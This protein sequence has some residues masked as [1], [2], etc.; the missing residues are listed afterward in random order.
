[1]D[2]YTTWTKT[3]PPKANQMI[4]WIRQRPQLLSYNAEHRQRQNSNKPKYHLLK[5]NKR[6]TA[7]SST[8][9]WITSDYSRTCSQKRKSY[10]C[11]S[12]YSETTSLI[13]GRHCASTQKRHYKTSWPKPENSNHKRTSKKSG[14][15]NGSTQ[16]WLKNWTIPWTSQK[17]QAPWQTSIRAYSQQIYFYILICILLIQIQQE[18]STAGKT[19]A[20]T[21]EIKCWFHYQQPL[22]NHQLHRVKQ[23]PTG[24]LY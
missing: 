10:N 22:P 18:I 21:D 11:A 4:T 1:M 15:T 7:I 12:V 13:F 20:S 6:S 23:K 9:S 2:V 16:I 5:E 17:T 14:G 8:Y 3:M 19:A 24:T